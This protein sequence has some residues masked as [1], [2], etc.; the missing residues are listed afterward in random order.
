MTKSLTLLAVLLTGCATDEEMT[1][2]KE[3]APSEQAEADARAAFL[4]WDRAPYSPPG[5]PL[6]VGDRVHFGQLLALQDRFAGW[7]GGTSVFWAAD[8]PY[9]AYYSYDLGNLPGTPVAHQVMGHHFLYEGHYPVKTNNHPD[10]W[11]GWEWEMVPPRLRD[12]AFV[13][14]HLY[15]PGWRDGTLGD[16]GGGGC[17]NLR[18]NTVSCV[19]KADA[20]SAWR[21]QLHEPWIRKYRTKG[22][23]S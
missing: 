23:E 18:A 11:V 2:T 6:E 15:D 16:R 10:E 20:I 5:W 8:R 9:G 4:D 19:A 22:E 12:R 1:G 21:K 17:N 14:E 3:P 13:I 7:Q